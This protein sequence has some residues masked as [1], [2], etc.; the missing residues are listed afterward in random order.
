MRAL[1][2]YWD[3]ISDLERADDPRGVIHSLSRKDGKIAPLGSERLSKIVQLKSCTRR[4]CLRCSPECRHI[5]RA[6]HT[7][8]ANH[9]SRRGRWSSRWV[10]NKFYNQHGG[11]WIGD[12]SSPSLKFGA[13]EGGGR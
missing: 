12:G 6:L 9:V 1:L 10:F 11:G 8:W 7:R 3:L 2:S 4:A 13:G 5:Q